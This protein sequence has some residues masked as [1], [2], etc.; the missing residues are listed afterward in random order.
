MRTPQKRPETFPSS[1][2]GAVRGK[3]R[4]GGGLSRCEC[5]REKEGFHVRGRSG[6]KKGMLPS[7]EE[8]KFMSE[9]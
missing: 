3:G 5:E 7:P 2:Q 6:R 1:W 9:I 4:F 8:A